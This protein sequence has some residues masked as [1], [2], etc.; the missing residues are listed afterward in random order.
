M[1]RLAMGVQYNGSQYYG[2]Q[3]QPDVPSVQQQVEEAVSRVADHP[4]QVICAG[5]T[6]RGVHATGQVIHFDTDAKRELFAWHRGS[7]ANLPP[8]VAINWVH[9]VPD[10]FHARFSARSREYRYILYN[11]DSRPAMMHQFVKWE[12][13]PLDVVKMHQAGQYLLGEHDFS[14]FRGAGCQAK[15]AT[16]TVHELQVTR[17]G[18]MV[19][20]EIK[21]NAFLLHMV[22]NIVG[23]LLRV[24]IGIEPVE[25]MQ[26]VLAAKDRREAGMTIPAAGL[27]LTKVNYEAHFALPETVA[28]DVL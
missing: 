5:R 11:H 12:S 25:W 14:S 17:H 13:H 27:S 3:S 2:W 20:V 8:D 19:C 1:P 7:N 16:R 18:L 10:D 26:A 24:G 23:S 6:D 9:E 4:V 15:T 22:R 21:A 28:A